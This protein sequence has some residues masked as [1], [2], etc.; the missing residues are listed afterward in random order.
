[1]KP[2]R[3]HHLA[4]I[5]RDYK[6]SKLFYVDVLGLKILR[7]VYR[8]D[9]QSYKLDLEV[10]GSYQIEQFSFLNPPPPKLF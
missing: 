10:I 2:N 7:E 5:C 6:K 9:R 1:M 8:E 3:I 4:I